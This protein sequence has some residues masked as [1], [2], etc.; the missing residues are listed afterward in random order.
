MH[1][2]LRHI[3]IWPV[4][5][6]AFFV[7]A[8]L[9]FFPGIAVSLFLWVFSNLIGTIMPGEIGDLSGF[10]PAM[11][12]MGV[13]LSPLYGAIGAVFAGIAAALYNLLA[14][15]IGGV[16]LNMKAVPEKEGQVGE[17]A[18]NMTPNSIEERNGSPQ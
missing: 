11:L 5:K 16:E 8:I 10:P 2:E 18:Q 17:R 13:I 6:I 1:Y 12:M 15:W 4:V 9:G 7:C 14:R 3:E